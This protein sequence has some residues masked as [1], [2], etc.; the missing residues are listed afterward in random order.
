MVVDT[1][2]VA[3]AVPLA[4]GVTEAGATLQVTV[5]FTGVIPQLKATAELKPPN[6]VIVTAAVVEFPATVVAVE[7][8]ILNA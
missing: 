5:A 6:E 4:T 8:E 2:N 7:G 1:V 3:N